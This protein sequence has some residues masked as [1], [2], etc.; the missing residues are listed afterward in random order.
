MLLASAT[1]GDSGRAAVQAEMDA[2]LLRHQKCGVVSR[3]GIVR[4]TP[5]SAA[6]GGCCGAAAGAVA[7]S[8]GAVGGLGLAVRRWPS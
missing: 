2:T 7:G 5:V 6:A 1:L 8:L 4:S 3:E